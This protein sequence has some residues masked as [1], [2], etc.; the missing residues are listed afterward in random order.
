MDTD[1][2]GVPVVAGPLAG[3][4]DVFRAH[5]ARSGYAPRSARDLMRVMARASWAAPLRT[6]WHIPRHQPGASQDEGELLNVSQAAREL[7][8]APS[9]LLRWLNDGFVAGEQVTPAP[10]GVSASPANCAP[11]SPTTHPTAGSPS[12]TPPAP[13]ASP[14][15]PYCSE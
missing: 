15:R 1:G 3:Y 10:P 14:A 4:Q 5:L 2:R 7:Q 8:I 13:S 12:T 6:H 9:T 11:C